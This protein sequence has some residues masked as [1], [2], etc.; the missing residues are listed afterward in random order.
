MLRMPKSP[1][2]KQLLRPAVLF[3]GDASTGTEFPEK[4][5]TTPPSG[6]ISFVETTVG[7]VV[8]AR[9]DP[10]KSSLHSG[11]ATDTGEQKAM[12]GGAAVDKVELGP[13]P[14]TSPAQSRCTV[15]LAC[16]WR[17]ESCSKFNGSG[18][19]RDRG[20][21]NWPLPS[22]TSP[23]RTEA[24]GESSGERRELRGESGDERR[25]ELRGESRGERHLPVDGDRE[26]RPLANSE[27][28]PNMAT[29]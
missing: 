20:L 6:I 28:G 10:H 22:C 24:R 21:S 5:R 11:E 26:A 3:V 27:G 13:A 12:E 8:A 1:A 4:L 9:A 17:V 29:A 18:F 16:D 2:E 19:A 7:R 14:S 23:P 15:G 25:T